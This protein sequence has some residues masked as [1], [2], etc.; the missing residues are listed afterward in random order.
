M[1]RNPRGFGRQ[2]ILDVAVTA[3]DG[4]S[5]AN[6]DAADRSLNAR[7]EQKM[8]KH[9]RLANQNGFHLTPT[10]FSHTGQIHE[11]I[12]R[13]ITEQIYHRLMLSEGEAKQS[14]VKSTIRWWTKCVSA[15]IAETAGRNVATKTGKMSEAAL[16]RLK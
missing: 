4:Q 10:V 14:R 7:Y 13:L 5:R 16:V 3:V 9:H 11:S 1:L 12:K 6:D 15:V 2:V 8:A